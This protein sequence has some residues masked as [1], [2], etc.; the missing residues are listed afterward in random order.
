MW[1]FLNLLH[2]FYLFGFFPHFSY[3]F[4]L[5]NGLFS[6]FWIFLDLVLAI[7]LLQL[8]R[9]G[10]IIGRGLFQS[11]FLQCCASS[12]WEPEP[13]KASGCWTL[14]THNLAARNFVDIICREQK[15]FSPDAND[16]GT[17]NTKRKNNFLNSPMPIAFYSWFSEPQLN[18][19]EV[20]EENSKLPLA[21]MI[22][23]FQ[24]SSSFPLHQS[25]S[26][27]AVYV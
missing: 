12:D 23:C 10:L 1:L 27:S 24:S 13:L 14:T 7:V 8:G 18:G 20:I 26:L 11:A 25:Q 15:S 19:G 3:H 17:A 9:L 5:F 21:Q 4:T 2:F 16:A 6:I 22:F